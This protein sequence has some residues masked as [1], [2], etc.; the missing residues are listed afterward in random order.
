MNVFISS[1]CGGSGF[2]NTPHS[3]LMTYVYSYIANNYV[4][5]MQAIVT[6]AL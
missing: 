4:F 5:E 6:E 3:Y 1:A 2:I